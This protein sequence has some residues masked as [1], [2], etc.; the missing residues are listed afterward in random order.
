MEIVTAEIRNENAIDPIEISRVG[1]GSRFRLLGFKI[2]FGE[3]RE[4]YFFGQQNFPPA[5]AKLFFNALAV[6]VGVEPL[7]ANDLPD[8]FFP[9]GYNRS[10]HS[11]LCPCA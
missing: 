9:Q 6:F 7:T 5:L 3:L 8:A 2:L 11:L 1:F 10:R 4:N